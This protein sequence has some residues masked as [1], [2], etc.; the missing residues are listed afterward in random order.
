MR[1]CEFIKQIEDMGL[2]SLHGTPIKAK[3]LIDE[4]EL[5]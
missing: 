2:E 1:K 3:E 5:D 4:S